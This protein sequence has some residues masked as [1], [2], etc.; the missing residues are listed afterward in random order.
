MTTTRP[1]PL[2]AALTARYA[3]DDT[4][5]A[6]RL[7]ASGCTWAIATARAAGG[8]PVGDGVW[9]RAEVADGAFGRAS[10]VRRPRPATVRR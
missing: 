2:L 10:A 5:T 6:A 7:D 8:E 4:S 9:T 3:L 1:D